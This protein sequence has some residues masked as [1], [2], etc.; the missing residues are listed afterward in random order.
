M[1][2]LLLALCVTF[3][4]GLAAQPANA[5]FPIDYQ[6]GD[7]YFDSFAE[8]Y[9][10]GGGNVA[11]AWWCWS[12]YNCYFPDIGTLHSTSFGQ[13]AYAQLQGAP[14][15]GMGYRL[16]YDGEDYYYFYY[17][18]YVT[19]NYGASWVFLGYYPIAY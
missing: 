6:D 10:L 1:K 2:K 7:G 11:F 14:A 16:W 8:A 3:S 5:Y 15:G 9:E 4:L 19:N 18:V 17:Q 13:P 12:A